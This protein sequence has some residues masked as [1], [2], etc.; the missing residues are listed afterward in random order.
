MRFLSSVFASKSTPIEKDPERPAQQAT[1]GFAEGD[2]LVIE[3]LKVYKADGSGE[4]LVDFG[5][6]VF[7]P[8]DW[9]QIEGASGCGKSTFLRVIKDSNL[10]EYGSSGKVTK[11]V[12]A[13][14]MFI[15]SSDYLPNVCGDK[16]PEAFTTA[17][18]EAALTKAGLSHIVPYLDDETKKR[19]HWRH[20]SDGQKK[21][22]SIARVLL[23]KPAILELDEITSALDPKSEQDLYRLLVQELPNAIVLSIVHREGI[24]H[25]H[26]VFM[27]VANGQ[28]DCERSTVRASAGMRPS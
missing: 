21:R 19:K 28:A 27:K 12:N 8:G 18:V 22:L 15:P 2:N 7:S 4:V 25:M 6:H 16:G 9:V 26:N 20:L 13:E 1:I 23:R 3:N 10:W 17:Q 11:P 24:R 5:S 14:E